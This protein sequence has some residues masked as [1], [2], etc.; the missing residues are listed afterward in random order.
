VNH[1]YLVA[2]DEQAAPV[3]AGISEAN[4]ILATWGNA[5][6]A[7]SVVVAPSDLLAV[8]LIGAV[9]EANRIAASLGGAQSLVVDLR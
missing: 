2:T 9:E 1:I 4:D 8:E 3:L 6:I 7:D 5:P